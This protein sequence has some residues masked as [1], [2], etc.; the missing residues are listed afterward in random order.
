M[1]CTSNTCGCVP[2]ESALTHQQTNQTR[3]FTPTVDIRENADAYFLVADVPG[4]TPE[5]VDLTVEQGVLTLRASV[6][7]RDPEGARRVVREYGIGS[8]ERSFRIGEGI[9]TQKI[10]A[11]L[12]NGVLTLTLP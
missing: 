3:T 6:P 9:D 12:K 4:A 8:Y 5:G 11:D 1:T 7:A 10:S 2:S